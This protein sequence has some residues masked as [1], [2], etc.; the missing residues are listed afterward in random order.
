MKQEDD[1]STID[2]FAVLPENTVT[3]PS[4]YQAIGGAFATRTFINGSLIK[5]GTINAA[6]VSGRRFVGSK[7]PDAVRPKWAT[8]K[9]LVEWLAKRYTAKGVFDLD[10][11]AET[12]NAKAAKYYTEQTNGLA[13]PW[14]SFGEDVFCNP[15]YDEIMP[16]VEWAVSECKRVKNLTVCMVL[17]N[18]IST[19]WFRHACINAAEIVNLISDGKK[20]GRVAFV[21]PVTGKEGRSNNKGTTVFVFKTKK[22]CSRT[23]YLS[24][25]DMEK[26]SAD[27]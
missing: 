13:S 17:P 9:W 4:H 22:K 20:S 21:D 6:K 18:D 3:Q 10:A 2:A 15:P 19:A 26:Q 5:H 23:L 8:P 7:T 16:W 14:D 27:N 1:K 11:A 24:R 12:V 25:V